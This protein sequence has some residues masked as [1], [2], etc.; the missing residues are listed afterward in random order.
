MVQ[1]SYD[2][3]RRHQSL[4]GG[5]PPRFTKLSGASCCPTRN[6]MSERNMLISSSVQPKETLTG[7]RT[8]AIY[9]QPYDMDSTRKHSIQTSI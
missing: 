9:V 3:N 8:N 5:L 7:L 4:K 1:P 6:W 2:D